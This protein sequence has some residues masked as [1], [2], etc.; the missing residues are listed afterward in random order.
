M[1]IV[2]GNIIEP[3]DNGEER[4][5]IIEG[6]TAEF[7]EDRSDVSGYFR[8]TRIIID[9]NA[10]SR[11]NSKAEVKLCNEIFDDGYFDD[12]GSFRKMAKKDISEKTGVNISK[13]EI[14]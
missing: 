11:I 6:I 1:N 8:C 4:L 5:Y 9:S 7:E 10:P 2:N 14:I 13:I 3:D 12:N